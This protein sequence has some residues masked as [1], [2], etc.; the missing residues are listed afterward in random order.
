MVCDGVDE[1]CEDTEGLQDEL[2]T[3]V[4]H[5][6]GYPTIPP[7]PKK[8]FVARI[9]N[10]FVVRGTWCL[11]LGIDTGGLT[12]GV[13]AGATHQ[14]DNEVAERKTAHYEGV[15]DLRITFNDALLI[16]HAIAEGKHRKFGVGVHG[17]GD[18]EARLFRYGSWHRR[19]HNAD[20]DGEEQEWCHR[21]S[22]QSLELA[23]AAEMTGILA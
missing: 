10:H 20:E 19:S 22:R 3:E 14:C 4:A 9:D 6:A 2:V 12:A 21:K 8:P 23:D 13:E 7:E 18:I 5:G 16:L 17:N 1:G 15:V 11:V